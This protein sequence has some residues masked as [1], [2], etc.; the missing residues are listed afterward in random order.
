MLAL[1]LEL[2]GGGR[3]V[4]VFGQLCAVKSI[5][6]G[7]LPLIGTENVTNLVKIARKSF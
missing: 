4:G 3:T 1:H 5:F 7:L 2:E 6:V